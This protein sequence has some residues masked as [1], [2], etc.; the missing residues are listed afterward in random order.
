[1]RQWELIGITDTVDWSPPRREPAPAEGD[2]GHLPAVLWTTDGSMRLRGISW[3]ASQHLGVHPRYL[4][5]KELLE[6]FGMEGESLPIL[7]A[8]AAALTGKTVTFSLKG[9]EG[10][11]RCRVAP[12]HDASENIVGTFCIAMGAVTDDDDLVVGEQD[13]LSLV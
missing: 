1:M 3:V 9:A 4:E 5:G 12:T 8:H 7:E 11:M 2:G 10:R 13:T 6:A